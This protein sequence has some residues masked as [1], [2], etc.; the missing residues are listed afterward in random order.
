MMYRYNQQKLNDILTALIKNSL[1]VE[2]FA[3]LSG[4]GAAAADQRS[5][6]L[7]FAMVPRKT[8]RPVVDVASEAQKSIEE[9]RPGF[10]PAGWTLDRL[11]RVWLLMQCDPADRE[12][13]IASI[14]NLFRG[15]AVN[16]LVALYSSLPVLAYPEAWID[17]CAEGIRSN[18]GDVLEAVM[19]NNPYPSEFLPE[20]AWN[21]MMMKAFF[22]EKP[23]HQVIGIDE[24]ANERLAIT[25]SDY[26]HE[27]WAAHRDVNPLI[28]R[29]VSP[30]LNEKIFP[31]I[32]RIAASENPFERKA[33]A[34]A[35]AGSSYPPARALLDK[36]LK[37]EPD[38]NDPGWNGL[39]KKMNEHVLQ[40]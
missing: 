18:I 19:C 1:P 10:R 15:A 27:R 12:K 22:T 32:Q 8:G 4:A 36:Q 31:D 7:A 29:C 5:F 28:W 26:A 3:W 39:A 25:L 6:N 20:P 34:L 16:E 38:H 35:C 23:V 24:R 9:A 37:N 2:V 21:Q 11:V 40:P 14:D 33:A 30:F 17:R 13:Y